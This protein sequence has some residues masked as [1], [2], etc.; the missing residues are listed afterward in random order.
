MYVLDMIDVTPFRYEEPLPVDEPLVDREVELRA[1][2]ERALAGRNTRLEA[3]RRYGKTSLLRHM[4]ADLPA[5][6][7]GVYVDLYGVV[8]AAEVIARL[9]RA[10]RMAKLPRTHARWLESRLRAST[11]SASVRVGPLSVGRNAPVGPPGSTEPGALED[12]LAIFAE[13]QD[14]LGAPLIV[15]LDEFQAVL[16]AASKIDAVI[17]SVIQHHDR[18]GYIFAGSHVGMMRELF[19]DRAR[20]FHAQAPPVAFGP[21]PPEPLADYIGPVFDR[22]G[23]DCQRVLGLLLEVARGHPQ[24]SMMLAAHLYARTPGGRPADEATF[25]DALASALREA[26]G[27]LHGRWDALTVSQRRAIAA[28]ASG[29]APFSRTAAREH[30]TSKGATG[31]ALSALAETGDI[32]PD[33]GS[34]TGWLIID[35][36]MQE[37]LRR[38]GLD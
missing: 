28:L 36:F 8:S 31:K 14:R 19:S 38:R 32:A 1:L 21:L 25:E 2:S 3:P 4:I 37:W 33:T 6:S 11:R 29:E 20:P 18:V 22:D 35:P 30:G 9:E 16:G 24:R 27:E 15:V 26:D 34:A 23:R 17:R 10:L 13:L 7:A 12:R 5:G